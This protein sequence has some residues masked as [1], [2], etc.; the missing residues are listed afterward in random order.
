MTTLIEYIEEKL[1]SRL[2]SIKPQE[3]S[4]YRIIEAKR[5]SSATSNIKEYFVI[6]SNDGVLFFKVTVTYSWLTAEIS[7]SKM[8]DNVLTQQKAISFDMEHLPMMVALFNS[9]LT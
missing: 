2:S 3:D 6:G 8:I 5:G 4:Y 7:I 9:E 1:E